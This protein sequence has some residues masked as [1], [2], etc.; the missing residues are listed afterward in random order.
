MPAH[1][2]ADVVRAVRLAA[3][4]PPARIVFIVEIGVL[5][6]ADNDRIMQE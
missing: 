1:C 3:G 2:E 5:S 4:V 6:N